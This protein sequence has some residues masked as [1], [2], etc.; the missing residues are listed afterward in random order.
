MTIITEYD[1]MVE[2]VMEWLM[3]CVLVPT[4]VVLMGLWVVW[5]RGG[6]LDMGKGIVW[7]NKME[8]MVA[9]MMVVDMG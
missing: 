2:R 7:G 9:M 8:E 4:R 1:V 6:T 5:R 3:G